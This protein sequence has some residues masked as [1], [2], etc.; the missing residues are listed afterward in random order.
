M[1][2]DP[3]LALMP[4]AEGLQLYGTI[5]QRLLSQEVNDE[6][7][8]L[9]CV[10]P[11]FTYSGLRPHVARWLRLASWRP[12]RTGRR[13]FQRQR[14]D[15]Q[16]SARARNSRRPKV[17][18]L[19]APEPGAREVCRRLGNRLKNPRRGRLVLP[20]VVQHSRFTICTGVGSGN[21][22]GSR[23]YS[24]RF[25]NSPTASPSPDECRT[26]TNFHHAGNRRR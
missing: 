24:H 25:Q 8:L 5:H 7:A 12:K 17:R 18:G 19:D 1:R 21:S 9:I 13:R 4:S 22:I 3:R 2:P 14:V 23:L 15:T 6:L 20:A 26:R 16:F 10:H 11:W